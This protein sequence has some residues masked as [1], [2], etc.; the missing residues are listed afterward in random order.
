[1]TYRTAFTG[2]LTQAALITV[3]HAIDA[4]GMI[5]TTTK[6]EPG[7]ANTNTT[8]AAGVFWT[9]VATMPAIFAVGIKIGTSSVTKR[10]ALLAALTVPPIAAEP[11]FA[12]VTTAATVVGIGTQ[13]R[14]GNPAQ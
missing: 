7:G 4:K 14:A 12:S 5:R 1:M 13:I 3:L 11:I 10:E 2:H 8:G 9:R 6:I